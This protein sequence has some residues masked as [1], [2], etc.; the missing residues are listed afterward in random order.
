MLCFSNDVNL[1]G[2]RTVGATAGFLSKL[3]VSKYLKRFCK[4][5]LVYSSGFRQVRR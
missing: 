2:G 4:A 1:P 5:P 3:L